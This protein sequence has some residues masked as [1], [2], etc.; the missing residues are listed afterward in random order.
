[1]RWDLR[2][3]VVTSALYYPELY[4][5]G[6]AGA[7]VGP[8]GD[9]AVLG[10]T[11]HDVAFVPEAVPAEHFFLQYAPAGTSP[12]LPAPEVSFDVSFGTA[13]DPSYGAIAATYEVAFRNDGEGVIDSARVLSNQRSGT[14]CSDLWNGARVRD[15]GPGQRATGENESGEFYR[16]GYGPALLGEDI[17]TVFTVAHVNGRPSGAGGVVVDSEVTSLREV[18]A[19]ASVSVAPNP[20]TDYLR[21]SWAGQREAATLYTALGRVAFRQNLTTATATAVLELGSLS[22]GMYYLALAGEAGTSVHAVRVGH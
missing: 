11:A 1:M 3:G 6:A 8:A 4:G 9:L 12:Y 7:S 15:L 17:E 13:T 18:V 10:R 14:F 5:W 2:T 20:A 16:G 19:D 21:V 22:P